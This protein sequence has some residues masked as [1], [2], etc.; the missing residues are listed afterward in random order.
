MKDAGPRYQFALAVF[1][2][3]S[4]TKEES[5]GTDQ[6]II[7]QGL[8]HRYSL[9]LGRMVTCG[10]DEGKSVVEVDHFRLLLANN[11]S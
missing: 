5:I 3:V 4:V 7:V 10:R 8:Y 2:G 6:A 1:A 9:G 11:G